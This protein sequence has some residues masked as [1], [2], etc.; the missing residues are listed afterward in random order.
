MALDMGQMVLGRLVYDVNVPALDDVRFERV[1]RG[2]ARHYEV[3]TETGSRFTFARGEGYLSVGRW[4]AFGMIDGG[5]V[6]RLR[7]SRD[8]EPLPGGNVVLMPPR[9]G[10]IRFSL[11]M[12]VV[13]AFWAFAL[14]C[15]WFFIAGDWI[16]WLFGY[17]IAVAASIVMIR[18]SLAQKLEIWL[19]KS[20]WN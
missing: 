3:T 9:F 12:R 2:F 18:R 4:D 11:S 5:S 19:A 10:A 8:E 15:G 20:T 7:Q 14:F 6:E 17:F 1:V 13:L 16:F